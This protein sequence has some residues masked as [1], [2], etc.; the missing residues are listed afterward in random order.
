MASIKPLPGRDGKPRGWKVRYWT[1]EGQ[2]RSRTFLVEQ[3]KLLRDARAFAHSVEVG[4]ATGTYIDD[5][6]GRTTVRDYAER[7]RAAQLHRASSARRVEKILRCHLYPALGDRPLA[8]VRRSDMQAWLKSRQACLAPT[9][10]RSSWSYVA[11]VFGAAVVDRYIAFSPCDGVRLE[12]APKTPIAVPTLAEIEAITAQLPP[13][14]RAL[15]MLGAQTGLRPGELLGLCVEQVDFLRRTL[16]VDRQLRDDEIVPEPKTDGSRRLVPLP[17]VTIE[18]LAGHL[19]AYPSASGVVF[20]KADGSG[21]PLYYPNVAKGWR[22]AV[23]RSGVGRRVRMHDMRHFYASALI[24]QGA[25]LVVVAA[26]LGHTKTSQTSD[27][28]AHLFPSEDDRTRDMVDSVFSARPVRVLA[29]GGHRP[30]V[31]R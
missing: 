8:S 18:L 14:W 5:R 25:G 3:G 11:A 4:K 19:A 17:R 15:A 2:P 13:R 6:L 21:R 23:A 22:R 24:S 9:T 28:Y 10:L 16:V 29:E 27:T 30:D 1:P 7:W 26:R 20:T 31:R 12:T